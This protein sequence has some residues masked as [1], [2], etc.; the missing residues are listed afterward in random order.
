MRV[1]ILFL[2]TTL[3]ESVRMRANLRCI[4]R[5]PRIKC[6]ACL[7]RIRGSGSRDVAGVDSRGLLHITRQLKQD[8]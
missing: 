5:T 2:V 8:V 4:C 1:Q 7:P 3:M 6:L